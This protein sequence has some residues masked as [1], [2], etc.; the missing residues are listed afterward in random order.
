MKK[1]L[2]FSFFTLVV[3]L[4]VGCGSSK[5]DLPKTDLGDIPEWY[6]NPPS[7]PNYIFAV[8]TETSRDLQMAVDKATT[9]ARADIARQVEVKMSGLEK[10]FKEEIGSGED[11]QLLSQ[12]TQATKTVTNQT[13][14]GSKVKEK[15]VVKDGSSYRAYVLAEY[16]IGAANVALMDALKKQNELYTRFRS[17]QTFDE[18]EK[19]IENYNKQK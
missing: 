16:P 11:S 12:F 1:Y 4:L 15:K 19:E 18:L 8:S 6:L 2:L 7:D 14:T 3:L 10:Q 5:V 9:G 17:S 13:L